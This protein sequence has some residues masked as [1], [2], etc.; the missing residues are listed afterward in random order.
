MKR[1]GTAAG[2]AA[3]AAAVFLS[4][5]T[6]ATFSHGGTTARSASATSKTSSVSS[7]SSVSTSST[8]GTTSTYNV[9]GDPLVRLVKRVEPAVVNVT[10]T[11]VESNPSVG[12]Q[13][14][15]AVGTGFIIDPDGV[16]VTND[17]VIENARTIR[18]TLISFA[19]AVNAVKPLIERALGHPIV[20]AA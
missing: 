1:A 2:A 16:I 12:Q 18:V 3:V 14:G 15:K 13:I 11:I 20:V 5:W 17:H 10:T 4:A 8:N 6:G 7:T 9:N 19:I